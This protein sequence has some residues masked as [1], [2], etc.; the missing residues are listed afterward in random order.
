MSKNFTGY[1]FILLAARLWEPLGAFYKLLA[2]SNLISSLE[3]VLWRGLFASLFPFFLL[4]VWRR[5]DLA[6]SRQNISLFIAIGFIGVA[7][8]YIVYIIYAITTCS[9]KNRWNH[10]IRWPT[11]Q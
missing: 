5:Q 11:Q 6:F 8:F 3:I 2:L 10:G 7:A 4:V 9:F 1:L